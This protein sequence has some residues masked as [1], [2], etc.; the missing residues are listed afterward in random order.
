MGGDPESILR[1]AVQWRSRN[2]MDGESRH[3]I[4]ENGKP[5][6][7]RTQREARERIKAEWGYIAHRPDLRA[8]PHGW[9]LP[10]AVRVRVILAP[11]AR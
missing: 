2:R 11:V 1:W 7:F 10:R 3:F 9:R 4:W 8:E 5:L 6:L